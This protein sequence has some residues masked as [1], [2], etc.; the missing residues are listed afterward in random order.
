MEPIP[1]IPKLLMPETNLQNEQNPPSFPETIQGR[2]GNALTI[3]GKKESNFN[4][5]ESSIKDQGS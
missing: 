3:F 5:I 2:P 1:A 4:Q